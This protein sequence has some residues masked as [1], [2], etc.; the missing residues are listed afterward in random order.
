VFANPF[1]VVNYGGHHASGRMVL[2]KADGLAN[3]FRVNLI[4]QI[5][6]ARNP[7]ILH[8]DVAKKTPRL[9]CR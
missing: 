9:L 1:H 7:R 6:D 3:D 8:Q 2:E 5:R 4:T